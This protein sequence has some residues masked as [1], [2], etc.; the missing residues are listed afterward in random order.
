[1]SRLVKK[2][3]FFLELIKEISISNSSVTDA[4]S[5]IPGKTGF[6]EK[7]I[8]HAL[9]TYFEISFSE[10]EK[11][12][13]VFFKDGTIE[14]SLKSSSCS[15]LQINS[16][17]NLVSELKPFYKPKLRSRDWVLSQIQNN[18]LDRKLAASLKR[19]Y[20]KEDFDELLSHTNYWLMHWAD[21]G[22]FDSWLE[23]HGS[24]KPSVLVEWLKQKM[25]TAVFAR[26]RDALTRQNT[27]ARTQYEISRGSVHE[28]S[29]Q[30]SVDTPDV[31]LQQGDK[32]G[33]FE[34]HVVSMPAE[35]S[36]DPDYRLEFTRD[37][38]RL[39]RPRAADRYVH[40]FDLMAQDYSLEQIADAIG[41]QKNRAAKLTQRVR[42]DLQQGAITTFVA[43]RILQE[44]SDEPYS[45]RE[46]LMSIISEDQ[47]DAF[48]AAIQILRYRNMIE[49]NRQGCFLA[50]KDGE[51]GL[52]SGELF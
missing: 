8:R 18:A 48:N 22:Q 27:G 21:I 14:F 45:T 37:L 20:K 7:H 49:E 42:D 36:I 3:Q 11:A 5:I 29:I 52:F 50:T 12:V 33:E 46:D 30:I 35:V 51:F 40:I 13:S 1:M 9:L 19:T 23:E 32:E 44:I 6:S 16:H 24:V 4:L 41:V 15:P 47:Q 10:L 31:V 17:N 39:S 2:H 43:K 26:G 38:I 25:R 34:Q 28:Q